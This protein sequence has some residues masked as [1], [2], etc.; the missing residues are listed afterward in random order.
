MTALGDSG[1]ERLAL[2]L[3]LSL[4]FG[5]AFEE[6][7]ADELARRPG[8]V[9]TFPLLALA[10]GALYLID[11]HYL[12][13]FLAGLFIVGA[14]IYAYVRWETRHVETPVD[15]IF[16]VPVCNMLAYLL[17]AVAFTQ[18]A[19]V[20]ITV[21]IVAVVL[22]RGRRVLHELADRVPSQEISTAAEFLIL[23]GVVLPLLA[24]R[25][26]IPYT[27]VTPFGVW[28]AVVAVSSISYASYLLQRYVFPGA[29][30]MLMSVLG[31]LYSSTA[32]TIVLSRRSHEEG[33]TR[34]LEAGLM[35]ATAMMYL[36]VLIICAFF[37]LS[38]AGAL[39][40]P[41]LILTAVSVILAVL[42]ARFGKHTPNVGEPSNPLQ[43]PT[44]LLFAVIFVATSALTTLAQSHLGHAGVLGLGALVGIA[45]VDPFL[46][47]L[48][49]GG[50]Q[51]VGLA[52]ASLA[53]VLATSTNNVLKAVCTVV[54]SRR[55]ESW[56]P[57]GV[58]TL[59]A[60]VAPV[61]AYAFVR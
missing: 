51:N 13:A 59:M 36:R 44:A 12:T 40:G 1:V 9:R 10:G 19:W 33:M 38:L 17:G 16:V 5:F 22:L 49:Q 11:R 55:R 42:R 3:A 39:M 43:I 18:P 37:N 34:E 6:F 27:T 28:L 35:A 61:I 50:V 31:G 8:G 14:W 21:A 29:G 48:A 57:A 2:L 58:L 53:I 47:S 54:F 52:T 7:Y 24:G 15:G 32:T 56:V 23:V 30:T 45:D 4:F 60:I 25:P 26:R 20:T 41:M 46:L